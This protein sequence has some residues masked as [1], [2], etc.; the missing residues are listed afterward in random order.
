MEKSKEGYHQLP[1]R[2]MLIKKLIVITFVFNI[3]NSI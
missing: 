3:N 1:Y 2:G